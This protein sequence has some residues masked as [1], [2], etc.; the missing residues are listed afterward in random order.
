MEADECQ[1]E[2]EHFNT[3]AQALLTY[4]GASN[5]LVLHALT[6]G[7]LITVLALAERAGAEDRPSRFDGRQHDVRGG[8]GQAT[9]VETEDELR[10][11]RMP[12]CASCRARQQTHSHAAVGAYASVKWWPVE[13][14]HIDDLIV[15]DVEDQHAGPW[16]VKQD[17]AVARAESAVG[18]VGCV[19]ALA[20]VIAT[21]A[22]LHNLKRVDGI[23]E[24]SLVLG[25]QCV[26]QLAGQLRPPVYESV[27]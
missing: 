17:V 12:C 18:W 7:F 16:R 5:H 10:Q 13:D 14:F 26:T 11:R 6:D 19:E 3:F 8:S 2:V 25:D 23:R 20:E 27:Y 22:R 15:D 4:G 9:S 1:V 21:S 24:A